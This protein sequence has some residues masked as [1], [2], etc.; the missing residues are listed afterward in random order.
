MIIIVALN[1][2]SVIVIFVIVHILILNIIMQGLSK[3]VIVMIDYNLVSSR[4][5]ESSENAVETNVQPALLKTS[6]KGEDLIFINL[7]P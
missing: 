4:D 2:T 7:Q 3:I 1:I 6:L 5:F